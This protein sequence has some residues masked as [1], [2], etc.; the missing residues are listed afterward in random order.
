M[1]IGIS[2]KAESGKDT[3]A[4]MLKILYGNPNI[5]YEDYNN[6]NYNKFA[7]IEVIHFADILKETAMTMC[8]LSE[9][10]VCTQHDKKRK[11]E[12]LGKNVRELLQ[13]IVT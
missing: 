1:I 11:I 10:D 7:D 13:K 9:E 5:S 3:A 6:K 8:V 2:G 12:W 4:N